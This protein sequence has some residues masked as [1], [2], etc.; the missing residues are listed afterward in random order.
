MAAGRL[1]RDDPSPY[2]FFQLSLL[3]SGVYLFTFALRNQIGN[4][5]I[6]AAFLGFLPLNL[7]LAGFLHKDP[8][9]AACFLFS[10]SSMYLSYTRTKDISVV[11]LVLLGCTIFLGSVLRGYFYLSALPIL[12]FMLWMFLKKRENI[13]H[14]FAWATTL[15]LLTI[16]LFIFLNNLMVYGLLNTEKTYKYQAIYQLDMAAIY[17]LTGKPYAVKFLRNEFKNSDSVKNYYNKEMN[18]S[19]WEIMN[20]YKRSRKLDDILEMKNEWIR[21]LSENFSVYLSHKKSIILKSFGINHESIRVYVYFNP[22]IY[23]N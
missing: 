14:P 7:S 20:I 22:K 17:A 11:Q 10:S 18:R 3:W 23:I 8:L 9:L 6:I 4:W 19:V 15:S 12:G 2:L 16:I 21:A 1:L 5:A 13:S